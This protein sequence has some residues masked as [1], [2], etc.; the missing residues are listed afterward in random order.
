M[1]NWEAEAGGSEGLLY[2]QL[3]CQPR[4]L[5]TL[6]GVVGTV[7]RGPDVLPIYSTPESTELSLTEC[8]LHK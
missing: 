8:L 7:G 1:G 2:P 4:V 3:Q 5:E 6:V